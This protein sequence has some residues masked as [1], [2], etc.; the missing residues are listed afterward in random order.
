MS[1]AN[2]PSLSYYVQRLADEPTEARRQEFYEALKHSKLG[3]RVAPFSSQIS[4]KET[5]VVQPSDEV[6]VC[7]TKG[8]DGNAM[9]LA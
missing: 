1:Q 4:Y 7:N 8:P 2:D 6:R 3:L 9:L 5:Y